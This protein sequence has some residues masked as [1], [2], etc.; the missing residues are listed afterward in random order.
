MNVRYKPI[1][2]SSYYRYAYGKLILLTVTRHFQCIKRQTKKKKPKRIGKHEWFELRWLMSWLT[3]FD[4]D[5][6]VNVNSLGLDVISLVWCMR[7]Y[8][9]VWIEIT[10]DASS[11]CQN[12]HKKKHGACV[13]FIP[14]KRKKENVNRIGF[15]VVR[16]EVERVCINWVSSFP[17]KIVH[18]HNDNVNYLFDVDD[19]CMNMANDR[20]V[21][22]DWVV[23]AFWI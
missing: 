6:D 19:E 9:V 8:S 18:T 2:C 11:R 7:F 16:C 14:S 5:V 20:A 3:W 12:I 22:A 23:L 4:V 13:L 21:A 17:F 15:I 10:V 1:C